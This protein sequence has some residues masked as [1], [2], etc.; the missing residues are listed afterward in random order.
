MSA[1]STV[2]C[3]SSRVCLHGIHHGPFVSSC[4]NDGGAQS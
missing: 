1:D 4:R 3:G 2:A